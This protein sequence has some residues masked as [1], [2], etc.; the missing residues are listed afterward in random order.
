M[1]IVQLI[2]QYKIEQNSVVMG[3]SLVTTI[4]VVR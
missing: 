3:I 4:L 1:L 2:R